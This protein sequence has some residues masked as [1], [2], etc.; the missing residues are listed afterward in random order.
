MSNLQTQQLLRLTALLQLE[1]RAR[2]ASLEEL[3]FVMVNETMGLMRYRQALLWQ[4]QPAGKIVA[5]SGVAA[6]PVPIAQT[7]S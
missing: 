3:G 2:A 7:G 1:K 5:V 6:L 4:H